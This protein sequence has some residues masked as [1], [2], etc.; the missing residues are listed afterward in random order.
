MKNYLKIKTI[1]KCLFNGVIK[2]LKTIAKVINKTTK[3]V[4]LCCG[5]LQ[6]VSGIETHGTRRLFL[7][8]FLEYSV[9]QEFS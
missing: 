5:F 6:S 1:Y 8:H 9:F 2:L 7:D 4:I 3:K